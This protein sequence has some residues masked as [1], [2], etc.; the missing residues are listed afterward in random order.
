VRT[1]EFNEVVQGLLSVPARGLAAK[2][3]LAVE[4]E[5]WEL[6]RGRSAWRR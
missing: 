6:P 4:E 1:V 2:I 5:A 3:A